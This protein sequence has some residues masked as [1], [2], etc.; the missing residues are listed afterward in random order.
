MTIEQTIV[1]AVLFLALVLFIAGRWRYDVVS[2]SALLAVAVTG[3]VP[4]ELVFDGFGHPAVVTVAAVLVV[5]RGLLNSGLIGGIASWMGKL[6]DSPTVVNLALTALVAV[7]SAFM[8]NVG[9][10]A[11]LMP[12]AISRCYRA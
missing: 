11:L 7:C 10:L 5:S 8:N 2:L 1:F 12:A 3:V 4:V 6:G 9:A